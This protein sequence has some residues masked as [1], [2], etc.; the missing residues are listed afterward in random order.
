MLNV[1]IID[2][3][4]KFNET[5]SDI[6]L[7]KGYTVKIAKTGKEALNITSQIEFDGIFIDIKL[8]DMSGLTLFK[9]LKL[10]YPKGSYFI[11]TGH[12]TLQNAV[13]AFKNGAN[14]YYL[15]PLII[16]DVIQR[17][18][19]LFEKKKIQQ[20]IIDSEKKFREACIEAEFYKDLL[21]HDMNNILQS[22]YS[23]IQVNELYLEDLEKFPLLKANFKIIKE[24]LERAARLI[25]NVRKL[26]KLEKQE[27]SI[28]KIELLEI[29]ENTIFYIKNRYNERIINIE[30]NPF[31]DKIYV[32]ANALIEEVFE[33]IL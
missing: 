21:S 16:E 14:G 10:K 26:S 7:E 8:P 30:V 11:I 27:I 17:V 6:F 9:E 5:V 19:E 24:Q 20:K 23:G 1:L 22:I 32:M 15:K 28:E 31:D 29:F 2:D 3:D 25:S 13:Q 12:G 18:Q 33:N 4:V